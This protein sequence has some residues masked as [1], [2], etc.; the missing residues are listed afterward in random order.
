MSFDLSKFKYIINAID[1]MLSMS[2]PRTLVNISTGYG[3]A[4]KNEEEIFIEISFSLENGISQIELYESVGFFSYT[5]KNAEVLRNIEFDSRYVSEINSCFNIALKQIR[6]LDRQY[7]NQLEID[8]TS[9]D[10]ASFGLAEV[11]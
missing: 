8:P 2:N 4:N 5:N 9:I 7:A 11:N 1:N 3:S 10:R 6:D